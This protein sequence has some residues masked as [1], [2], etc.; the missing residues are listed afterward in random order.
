MIKK[1]KIQQIVNC[2][3]TGSPNGDYGNVSIFND[4]PQGVK[5]LSYGKS[6]TTASGGLQELITDYIKNG[7]KFSKDFEPY[8]PN[9]KKNLSLWANKELVGLLKKAGEDPIMKSTQDAFFDRT[10]WAKAAK[11]AEVNG[12][13]ENLSLLVIYDSFIHS[14]CILSFLREKFS[15]KTPKNGGDEK[16]WI[17]QY[18]NVR[19]DW[20]ANHSNKILRKTIYRT[21]DMK[22][23]IAEKDWNLDLTFE[24]NG[25]KVS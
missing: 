11:W 19:H 4:G 25:E 17:T 5:Q 15:A 9:I 14:G 1:Q 2:F 23:A 18:I 13:I 21:N 6:Q 10:Y 24:A 16:T 20:L 7:G 3:E 8:A 22:K 12:F